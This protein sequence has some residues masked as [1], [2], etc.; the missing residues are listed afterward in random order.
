M[1]KTYLQ[2]VNN[3]LTRL[4]ETTVAGVNDTPYSSLIAVLVNDAKREVEDAHKWSTHSTTIVVPTVNGTYEYSLTGSGQRFKIDDVLNDTED[5]PVRYVANNWINRQ[6]YL[7]DATQRAAPIYY[8]YS[9]VDSNDDAKVQVWPIPDGVYSLRFELSI[10]QG[11]LVNNSD[12]LKVPAHLVE[13]LAYAKAVGERG[14]DGGANFSE[15]FQ[16]YRL[17]LAD[18]IALERNRFEEDVVWSEA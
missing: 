13:L 8:S 12:S 9:G 18:A 11:D 16:M 7:A 6:F 3:V 2:L 15:L 14:E 4:R 17:A 1:A 5:T 10:P